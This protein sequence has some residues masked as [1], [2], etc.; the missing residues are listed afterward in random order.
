[1]VMNIFSLKKEKLYLLVILMAVFA[2]AARTPLDSDLWWHLRA[3]ETTWE[4]R[5]PLTEDIYSY[6]RHGEDWINH[7]WL[8]QVALYLLYR[9]GGLRAIA[10]C[11]ALLAVFSVWMVYRQMEGSFLVKG[12]A[13]LL[14]VL[15]SAVVWSPRPQTFSL[16][17]FAVLAAL[18]S[19]YKW[20]G[21]NRL[22]WI[23]PLF[24]VWSNLHGGYVLGFMV[25]GSMVAGEIFNRL[26][27]PGQPH[28]LSW[29][30]IRSLVL[31]M[32]LGG[33][34]VLLNPNGLDMW[35]IP[36]QTV[37]VETLQD[38]ISEW[39]SPDFHRL[40]QQPF[41]WLSLACFAAVGLSR[42]RLDGSDFVTFGLFFY[43][44]LTARRNFGPFALV[45]GPILTRHASDVLDRWQTSAQK[46]WDWF[47]DLLDYRRKSEAGMNAKVRN[48][49][50]ILIVLF[51][52]VGG[53]GKWWY[54]T[55]PDFIQEAE[56]S[57][58]PVEAVAWIKTHQPQ[59]R[60][61]NEYKWGGYLIWHLRE[62]PVFVDGRTDLYGDEILHQYIQMKQGQKNVHDLVNKWQIKLFLLEDEPGIDI[63]ELVDGQRREFSDAVLIMK[64]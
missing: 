21:Q 27:H 24:I 58:Y 35:R 61:F 42:R 53:I 32:V 18:L 5:K 26:F 14:V 46:R 41:I 11:V 45:A 59:G 48:L 9:A 22:F 25:M 51:L 60:L 1:M 29:R 6:T 39:S 47:D 33:L 13:V 16:A 57:L 62:Y 54:V 4:D 31:W 23:V 63:T 55:R 43:A 28:S 52:T 64:P 3:G 34:L 30:Q 37:G 49:I 7:S 2:M 44:A 19:L 40:Y 38:L 10:A 15:V 17:L 56:R 36:F 20:Q 50:N 8:A 12:A